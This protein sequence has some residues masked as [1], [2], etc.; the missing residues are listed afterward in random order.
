MRLNYYYYIIELI[1]RDILDN[2]S[3]YLKLLKSVGN[4]QKYDF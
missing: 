3:E 2:E 4:N 1:K